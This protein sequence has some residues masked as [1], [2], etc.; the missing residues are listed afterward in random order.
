MRAEAVRTAEPMAKPLPVAAVVFPRASRASVVSRTCSE[1]PGSISAIPPALSAT[2]PYASVARVIP[3]VESIPTAEMAT[4]YTP[5]H[6]SQQM[7]AMQ[8]ERDG[9]TTLIMPTPRPWITT[10]AGPYSAALAMD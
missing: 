4:P 1:Q 8:M 9:T 2:G 6:S 10:V 5:A 3:R 7:I